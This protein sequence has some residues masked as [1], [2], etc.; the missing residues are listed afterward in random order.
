[1]VPPDKRPE[2][3]RMK[4]LCFVFLLSTPLAG[5]PWLFYNVENLFD[6]IHDRDFHD[7]EFTPNGSKKYGSISY[8]LCIRQTS[9]A[10]NALEHS[11]FGAPVIG[12]CEVEHRSVLEDLIE[13]SGMRIHGPWGIIHYDSPD[14]RGID[15]ALLYKK[16]EVS[17]ISSKRLRLSND[18]IKT[19]DGL[20]VKYSKDSAVYNV[21]VVHLPSKR[22]GS[23]QT[24]WKRDYIWSQLST[25]LD[26][27]T[28]PT[29]IMGDF[30]DGV[31]AKQ[32]DLFSN[33]WK[34]FRATTS[35][36]TY[37]YQGR[38]NIIDGALANFEISA[39]VCEL[40]LLL[41]KDKKWGGFKPRRR[42]QGNF[43]KNGYSDH[44][45]VYFRKVA[46][47]GK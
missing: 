6:T 31:G 25:R 4:V 34:A 39:I 37:K 47:I 42:W 7:H 27:C 9:R 26:S 16:A 24:N 18:S 11:S 35:K 2:F 43:Y 22:G 10:L 13:H 36:G 45:P 46:G 12:L 3:K 32:A 17:I 28:Q 30:N 1:M 14:F 8:R 5:Q 19:R 29:L 33:N 15:C 20:W 44:L 40:A 21:V 41:E 38:W 23:A